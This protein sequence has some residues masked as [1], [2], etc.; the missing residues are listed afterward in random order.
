M[1]GMSDTVL[2]ALIAS[3]TTLLL[4]IGSGVRWLIQRR[5]EQAKVKAT[6]SEALETVKVLREENEE[7]REDNRELR[8]VVRA[9]L[10]LLT[11]GRRRA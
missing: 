11:E 7:L 3:G 8:A 6:E 2:T 5:D 4:S 10:A 1:L 9:L